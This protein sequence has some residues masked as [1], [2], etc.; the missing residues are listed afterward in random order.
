MEIASVVVDVLIIKVCIL[1]ANQTERR[2][3]PT[4][5][6]GGTSLCTSAKKRNE[7]TVFMD[8]VLPS[9]S[10]FKTKSRVVHVREA[11]SQNRL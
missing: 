11:S 9:N 4:T 8:Y 2:S 5:E 3:A 1:P 7:L 10:L 6:I